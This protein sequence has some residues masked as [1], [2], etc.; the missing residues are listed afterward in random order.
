MAN[1]VEDFKKGIAF[2]VSE[3]KRELGGVRANRPSPS[4]IEDIK[5]NYYGETM[6]LKHVGSITVSPPRELSVQLWD[7]GA[8]QLVAKAI[9]AS[10]LGLTANIEGN[11]IRIF[12]PSLSAER[13]DEL[14]KHV[15]KIAEQYR[16]Q[17]RH[18]RETANKGIEMQLGANEIGEDQKFRLRDE[19]QKITENANKDVESAV[20][21]KVREIEE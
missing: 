12:L 10:S 9:E 20:S 11:V 7:A 2:V 1:P 18:H 21:A 13:R 4:L 3:C 17:I 8:V 19:V 16:I 5:V 15:K 14:V 6:P